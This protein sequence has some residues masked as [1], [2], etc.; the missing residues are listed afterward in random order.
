MAKIINI[1]DK[2]SLEKPQVVIGDDTYEVND[3]M[4]TVLKFQELSASSTDTNMMSAIELAIGKEAIEKIGL[5]QMSLSNFKV[6]T[7]AIMAAMQ[8]MDFDEAASRFQI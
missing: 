1:T 5:G 6:V 7:I 8:N 2:L 3:S 4:E